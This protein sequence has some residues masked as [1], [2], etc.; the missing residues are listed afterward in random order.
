MNA[1]F[2]AEGCSIKIT[3]SIDTKAESN[4]EWNT[5]RFDFDDQLANQAWDRRAGRAIERSRYCR[6]SQ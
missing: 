5:D 1:E 4:R 3:G 2:V 6:R